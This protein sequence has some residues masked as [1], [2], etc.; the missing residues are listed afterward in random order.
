VE[1][2]IVQCQV[3]IACC[4]NAYSLS[5]SCQRE[6]A[7][8]IEKQKF[9]IPVLIGA[10]ENWP[11]PG[12]MNVLLTGRIYFDLSTNEKFDRTIDLLVTAI[13]QSFN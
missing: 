5:T 13:N 7:S 3:F 6:L 1:N 8:A 10:I 9:I 4:S 11:L 2:N 12:Q